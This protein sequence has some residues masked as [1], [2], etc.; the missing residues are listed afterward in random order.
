MGTES[1]QVIRSSETTKS[2]V[3]SKLNRHLIVVTK[4][5]APYVIEKTPINNQTFVGND[6]YRGFCIEMLRKISLICN[7]TYTVK[8]V[9]DGFHGAFVNGKWNGMIAELIEKVNRKYL[10]L[11]I[12]CIFLR[13]FI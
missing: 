6:R 4:L 9:D 5:E 8:I 2:Q 12:F 1:I 11:L 10:F 13:N 3:D 7:F